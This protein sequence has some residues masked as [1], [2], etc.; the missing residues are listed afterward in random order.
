VVSYDVIINCTVLIN[1]FHLF[2]DAIRY[3]C[4]KQQSTIIMSELTIKINN[5][6]KEDISKGNEGLFDG[7]WTKFCV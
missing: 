4:H 6:L 7:L 1:C 3:L 2:L 5:L